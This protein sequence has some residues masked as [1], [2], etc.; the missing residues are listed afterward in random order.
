[1]VSIIL[2]LLVVLPPPDQPH[3]VPLKLKLRLVEVI[4]QDRR[5]A[6]LPPVEYSPE[7]SRAA[8]E[9]CREMLREGYASHWNRSGWKP[10][11]RYAQAGIR[12]ALEENISSLWDISFP[13]GE[14]GMWGKLLSSHRGFMAEQ[15]PFDGHRRSILGPNHTDVGIGAAYDSR[16]L[17]LI[18]VFSAR[19]AEL[20]PL[21]L[22]A[23]LKTNLVVRGRLLRRDL[24]LV[25][26][27][28]F[29]EPLPQP[30][31]VEQLRATTSYGWPAEERIE[32]PRLA[33]NT[34]YVDGTR[35]NIQ[36]DSAGTFILPLRF[37]KALPG[38][39]SVAV[40]VRAGGGKA[41]VG[42]SAAI[43]VEDA[44]GGRFT[45]PRGPGAGGP[46]PGA[47]SGPL[48]G[49]SEALRRGG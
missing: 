38:V 46:R 30:M 49:V 10:Y 43:L 32:R 28:V 42:A 17:R 22:H 9:H 35:G 39:Y 11:L 2:F 36:L 4:N 14:E 1:M 45:P 33:G 44:A 7:L 27:S 6:G 48:R 16:G 37:W 25:A 13:S 29:Y 15:P 40:W 31:S 8:D 21:P 12:D 19:V 18:E 23:N 47:S 24:E 34:S 20:E 41:F 5:Q 3:E 26:I